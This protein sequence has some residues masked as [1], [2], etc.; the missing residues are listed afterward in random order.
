[1]GFEVGQLFL[2]SIQPFSHLLD[3]VTRLVSV[4]LSCKEV[5]YSLLDLMLPEPHVLNGLFPA[6]ERITAVKVSTHDRTHQRR[7]PTLTLRRYH[8]ISQRLYPLLT[9]LVAWLRTTG[10]RL[11]F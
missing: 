7:L 10:R 2:L 3:A 9:T 6:G 5:V 11:V 8:L 4:A 1:M